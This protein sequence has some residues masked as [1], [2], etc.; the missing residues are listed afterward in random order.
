MNKEIEDFVKELEILRDS[1]GTRTISYYKIDGKQS[2]TFKELH[3]QYH[4]LDAIIKRW[5]DG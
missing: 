1:I 2:E 5:K 3:E 4:K